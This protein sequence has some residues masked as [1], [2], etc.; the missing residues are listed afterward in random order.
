MRG[1]GWL[2]RFSC[3][4]LKL[5]VRER[6]NDYRKH[7]PSHDGVLRWRRFDPRL[8]QRE[9]EEKDRIGGVWLRDRPG[10]FQFKELSFSKTPSASFLEELL[11]IA[12]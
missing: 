11:A 5:F 6:S 2:L 10:V 8:H 7:S 12:A 3:C 9:A 4:P 1:L